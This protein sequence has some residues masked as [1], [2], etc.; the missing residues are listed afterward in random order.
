MEFTSEVICA[1]NMHILKL[2]SEEVFEF[3]KD[4]MTT[5]KIKTMKESL[6][7]EFKQIFEL[8]EFILDNSQKPSLLP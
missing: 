8:C 4:Q 7:S 1:N 2:L 5:Q 6:N 3:S